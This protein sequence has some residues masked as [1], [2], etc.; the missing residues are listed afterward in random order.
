M[1]PRKKGFG[2]MSDLSNHLRK[3][4]FIIAEMEPK[5]PTM[6]YVEL[7][8]RAK[9]KTGSRKFNTW[10]NRLRHRILLNL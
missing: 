3:I 6:K 8:L 1:L 10:F 4:L 9:H 5:N 7:G 2:V